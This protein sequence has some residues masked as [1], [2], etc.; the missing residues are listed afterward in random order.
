[1]LNK[2]I[3]FYC[4]YIFLAG[5]FFY[6]PGCK[7]VELD[8]PGS[9]NSGDIIKVE[10][11]LTKVNANGVDRVKITATLMGNTPDGKIA[12]KTDYGTFAGNNQQQYDVTTIGHKAEVFLISSTDAIKEV[13]VTASIESITATTIIEFE[14]VFPVRIYLTG[15]VTRLKA[16]GKSTANI[17]ATLV[18]PENRGTVSK[19]A[20]VIFDAIDTETGASVPQLHREALSDAEGKASVAFVSH[21]PGLMEITCRIDDL[22]DV[23]A[24]FFIEFYEE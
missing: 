22:P 7:T 17:T 10:A 14:R 19:G 3:R 16:D 8:E 21:Q 6:S 9:L 11:A 5:L 13:T 20:R 23:T 2:N 18:P 1:M 4:I 12:F 24:T 15:N